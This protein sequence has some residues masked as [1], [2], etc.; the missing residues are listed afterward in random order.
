MQLLPHI[1]DQDI[2]YKEERP[3]CGKKILGFM[4]IV[5]QT[6]TQKIFELKL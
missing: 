4:G 5:A 1:L 3:K 2:T 6:Q